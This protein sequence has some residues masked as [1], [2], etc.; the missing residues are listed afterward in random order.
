MKELE[1][2]FSGGTSSTQCFHY[3]QLLKSNVCYLYDVNCGSHY[4]VFLRKEQ[5]AGDMTLGG[6]VIHLEAKVKYPNDE[7]FGV[8][9][10]T[11]RNLRSAVN[12]FN[13]L[14]SQYLCSNSENRLRMDFRFRQYIVEFLR[15]KDNMTEYLEGLVLND[16]K[17]VY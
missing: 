7:A 1:L 11:Y 2:E 5:D 3:K 10:W 13:L 17:K 16:M 4:E 12:R 8:W 9:A 14:N 15:E 6:K